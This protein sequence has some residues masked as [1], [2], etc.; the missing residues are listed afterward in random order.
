MLAIGLAA[1]IGA[2]PA[3][4]QQ[5]DTMNSTPRT[6]AGQTT[7]A[8]DFGSARS[9]ESLLQRQRPF[10]DTR[11]TYPS[12]STG[13]TPRTATRFDIDRPVGL[14]PLP[15]ARQRFNGSAT[16]VGEP[17]APPGTPVPVI[18]RISSRGFLSA[19]EAVGLPVV[20][21]DGTPLGH[22]ETVATNV[23][24]ARQSFVVRTDDAARPL[25]RI[26]SSRVVYDA[27]QGVLVLD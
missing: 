26:P 13:E 24:A 5:R 21:R 6:F 10:R 19:V 16:P 7:R 20:A 15:A 14:Q 22:V 9:F 8:S 2:A 27:A 11:L 12:A 18:D 1:L 17:D 25:M 23:A 3:A 4:A